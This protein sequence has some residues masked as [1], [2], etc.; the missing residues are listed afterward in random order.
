VYRCDAVPLPLALGWVVP[1]PRLLW[2][3]HSSAILLGS[4]FC[5]CR[6]FVGVGILSVGL[7]WTDTSKALCACLL[8]V[9]Y[10][11]IANESCTPPLQKK[12]VV[13]ALVTAAA[14]VAQAHEEHDAETITFTD[15]QIQQAATFIGNLSSF[16]QI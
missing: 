13:D 2:C 4:E 16:L 6:R 9:F 11:L 14:M 1:F 7:D 10:S 8:R 5:W 3:V 12:T 15:A